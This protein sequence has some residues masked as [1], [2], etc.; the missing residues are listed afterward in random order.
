MGQ[1][2]GPMMAHGPGS[3][4]VDLDL[5]STTDGLVLCSRNEKSWN[6]SSVWAGFPPKD[7]SGYPGAPP[8]ILTSPNR[9]TCPVTH[10]V[11]CSPL[12]AGAAT[13]CSPDPPNPTLFSFPGASGALGR[14]CSQL[15]KVHVCSL[16]LLL[17][18][19]KPEAFNCHLE[20]TLVSSHPRYSKPVG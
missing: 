19:S 18:Y 1:G 10:I 4:P 15:R 11:P 6:R 7:L 5:L 9:H 17:P 3:R 16:S 2:L 14:A 13:A 8:H 12:W 20:E